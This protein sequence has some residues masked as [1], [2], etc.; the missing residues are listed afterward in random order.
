MPATPDP[1]SGNVPSSEVVQKI[2]D[3]LSLLLSTIFLSGI[4]I[5]ISG[6]LLGYVFGLNQ[7]GEDDFT[8]RI[9]FM[10]TIRVKGACVVA[11][12][13]AYS[14]SLAI[15]GFEFSAAAKR[16]FI[17]NLSAT[18]S[19]WNAC[20]GLAAILSV[21]LC[22]VCAGVRMIIDFRLARA[23]VA[24]VTSTARQKTLEERAQSL[25]ED[26]KKNRDHD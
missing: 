16:V 5:A 26:P 6:H 22:L 23:A 20:Q 13:T 11:G 7:D 18:T 4:N 3:V 1:N 15:I 12:F 25:I 24:R 21:F 14:L 8:L 17:E 10:F 2:I 19:P 9:P